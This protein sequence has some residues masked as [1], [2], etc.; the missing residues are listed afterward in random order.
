MSV[1]TDF[2]KNARE[3]L[4]V[5]LGVFKTI[6]SQV[7]AVQTQVTKGFQDLVNRGA[8]DQSPVAA[9]LRTQL[10]KGLSALK[11]AQVRVEG[12]IKI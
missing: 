3:A 7:Q 5:G 2:E 12:A 9:N 6:E 1:A 8:A 10:D 4:N 11:D